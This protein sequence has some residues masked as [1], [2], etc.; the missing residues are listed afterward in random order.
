MKDK[1][2]IRL[3]EVIAMTGLSRS[4]IYSHMSQGSFPKQFKIGARIAVWR[5]SDILS[6]IETM[7]Q[8]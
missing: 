2:L 6:W 1:R 4:T 8:Q 5:E 3:P 7:E